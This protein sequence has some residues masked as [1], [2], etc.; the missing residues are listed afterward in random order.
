MTKLILPPL[1]CLLLLICAC[2]SSKTAA[3][4]DNTNAELD[5]LQAMMAGTFSSAAQSLEDTAYFS[6]NLVMYP[7]W[8][9]Q[10]DTRWLYVEQAVT[11]Y[12]D[13]PYRQRVYRLAKVGENLYESKVYELPQPER[14]VHGWLD[15]ALFAKISA[16]SL[17]TR[18]GCAVYLEKD[19]E[20]CYS[21][22]TKEK[23]CLS[24]LRG[25]TYATSKVNICED[26]VLSWD[27]GWSDTDEQ[28]WGAVKGGYVFQRID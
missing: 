11:A 16:D 27:Q 7:I 28:V 22:S 5:Q 21:G 4:K 3:G 24:S 2:S 10:S 23:D 25:A 18:Q 19:G 17:I 6:I 12:I 14:F 9:G 13:Q 8:E 20:G 1:A 15:P 26:A